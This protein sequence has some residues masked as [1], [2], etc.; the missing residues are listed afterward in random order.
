MLMLTDWLV[1]G[2]ELTCRSP[3]QT[4]LLPCCQEAGKQYVTGIRDLMSGKVAKLPLGD[5]MPGERHIELNHSHE[6][7]FIM[8]YGNKVNLLRAFN[9]KCG[10]YS[11]A[12]NSKAQKRSRPLLL[13]VAMCA[14]HDS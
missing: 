1:W 4:L 13:I 12:D 7:A 9:R 5:C 2:L 14:L 6:T 8:A 11:I 3:L 10:T